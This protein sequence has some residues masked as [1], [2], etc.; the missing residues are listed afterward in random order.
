MLLKIILLNY[1]VCL[2][3]RVDVGD[4]I[5]FSTVMCII[6]PKFVGLIST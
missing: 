3:N 2:L 6:P 4:W 1:L 5:G